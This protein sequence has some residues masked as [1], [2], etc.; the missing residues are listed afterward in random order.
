MKQKNL[1]SIFITIIILFFTACSSIDYKINSINGSE[2]KNK[3]PLKN[4]KIYI[5]NGGDGREMSYLSFGNSD[6]IAKGS[7]FS[8]LKIASDNLSKYTAN[9]VSEKEILLEDKALEIGAINQSDYLI[10]SRVEQWS[11]PLGINCHSHYYD[12]ASVLLSIYSVKDEKLIDTSRLSSKS[13]P[14]KMNGIPVSTGSPEK[15]YSVL[16]S[17]WLDEKFKR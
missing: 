10:Y 11:D 14:F 4:S 15:L 1:K 2:L 12:E 9:V 17:K 8:A 3:I 16:F 7:G 6:E 5:V 13:C